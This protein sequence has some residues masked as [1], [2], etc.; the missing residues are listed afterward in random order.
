MTY[1]IQ[2]AEARKAEHIRRLRREI[3]SKQAEVGRSHFGADGQQAPHLAG[4]RAELQA[5]ISDREAE[6]KRLGN[7]GPDKLIDELVPEIERARVAEKASDGMGRVTMNDVLPGRGP[8]LSEQVVVH[9][10]PP[11]TRRIGPE[12]ASTWMHQGRN[13]PANVA[14]TYDKDGQ[15][16]PAA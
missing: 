11:P 5:Q 7:L 1:G 16:V 2:I 13:M 8:Q 12:P 4:K 9:K 3:D 14:Y 6:I 10:D 15:L